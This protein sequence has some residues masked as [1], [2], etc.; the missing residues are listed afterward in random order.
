MIPEHRIVQR[1]SRQSH[2][3]PDLGI[4]FLVGAVLCWMSRPHH[5]LHNR[6][7]E[8]AYL[9]QHEAHCDFWTGILHPGLPHC[10]P[11]LSAARNR[12]HANEQEGRR[13]IA[14]AGIAGRRQLPRLWQCCRGGR[15]HIGGLQQQIRLLPADLHKKTRQSLMRELVASVSSM[16]VCRR[17]WSRTL[18]TAIDGRTCQQNS[19]IRSCCL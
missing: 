3:M 4:C 18:C 10:L 17:P 15:R 5:P 13:R 8:H 11:P 14:A 9:V 6:A 2:A 12:Q 1:T 16:P 19:P 7:G